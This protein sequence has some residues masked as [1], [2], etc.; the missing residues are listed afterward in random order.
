MSANGNGKATIDCPA[1]KQRFG[2]NLPVPEIT[3]SLKASIVVATHE[4]PVKCLCGQAFVPVIA[5]IQTQWEIQPISAEQAAMLEGSR[6][7]EPN[8][9]IV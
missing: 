1:C 5:G 6:I 9:R 8:L 2:V 3:N 4:K 7:I